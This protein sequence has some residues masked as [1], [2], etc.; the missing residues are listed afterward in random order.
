MSGGESPINVC[1]TLAAAMTVSWPVRVRPS[2]ATAPPERCSGAGVV[3][4]N[5]I[6]QRGSHLFVAPRIADV[7]LTETRMRAK[8][9]GVHPGE[10]GRCCRNQRFL[11]DFVCIR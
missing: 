3:E 5:R 2:A 4:Q 8:R 6:Q 9:I 10:E 1:S 7:D 11:F